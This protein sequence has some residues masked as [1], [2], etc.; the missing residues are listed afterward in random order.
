MTSG[1]EQE[2]LT[3]SLDVLREVGYD[4]LTM[5]AVAARARCSKATL[6]R[7]WSGKAEMVSAALYAVRPADSSSIDTGSLRGDLIAFVTSIASQAEVDT[8]LIAGLAH[9]ALTDETLAQALNEM[10]TAH[11]NMDGF[12]ERAVE[13]GELPG[14]PPAADFLPQMV[15]TLLFTRP[16]FEGEFADADY[17]QRFVD[18]ALL[19]ALLHRSIDPLRPNNS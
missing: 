2:L 4:A 13:R 8:P 1:R 3:A 10:L 6:Y 18:T 14:R 12:V 11:D 15:F 17:M 5:D 19:P 16:L 7:Q 9:A